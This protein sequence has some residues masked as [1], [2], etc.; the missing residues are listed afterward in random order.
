MYKYVVIGAGL[1][2]QA[3]VADL[4]KQPDTDTIFLIDRDY[5]QLN[6]AVKSFSSVGPKL[7]FKH[8]SK[9]DDVI[10]ILKE[11]DVVIIAAHYSINLEFTEMAIDTGTHL[12]DLGGNNTVVDLQHIKHEKAIQNEVSIIP[13]CGLAPGMVSILVKYGLEKFDSIDT[14]KI[15]VGGIPQISNNT[16]RYEKL[17]SVEGLINEYVEPVRVLRNGKI[18]IINPLTELESITF[19]G[20]GEFEAFTTSGGASTLVNTYKDQLLNLDYKTIRYPGHCYIIQAMRELG[21][22]SGDMR[23]YTIKAFE[24]N[25]PLCTDDITLVKVSFLKEGYLVNELSII[26][27][28][29]D[30]LTSMMRMTAFPV[31]IIAQMLVRGQITQRGVLKQEKYV[32]VN[33]FLDELRKRNIEIQELGKHEI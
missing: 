5:N 6:K 4:L 14:V 13:D 33:P 8:I 30:G 1:M 17:F 32:P 20:M 29:R 28:A 25:L 26:D 16:L 21:F 27:R 22:F 19:D 11:V 9:N 10:E 3:I 15:R 31:S 24:E 18:K 23:K 2:G 7:W 12:C